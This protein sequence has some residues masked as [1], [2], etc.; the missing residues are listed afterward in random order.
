MDSRTEKILLEKIEQLEKELERTKESSETVSPEDSGFSFEQYSK[1]QPEEFLPVPTFEQWGTMLPLPRLEMRWVQLDKV[2]YAWAYFLLYR[3]C[4]KEINLVHLTAFHEVH[5]TK[6]GTALYEFSLPY[7]VGIH[8]AHDAQEL[9]MPAF[10]LWNGRVFSVYM[11]N[12]NPKTS[13]YTSLDTKDNIC[14][15]LR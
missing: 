14:N 2:T 6:P 10:V 7:D 5:Q 3:N 11:E 1:D 15:N 13:L 4:A 8:I 12:G 9:R